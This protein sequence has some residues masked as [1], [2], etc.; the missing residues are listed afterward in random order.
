MSALRSGEMWKETSKRPSPTPA[1][2]TAKAVFPLAPH[3]I[4]TTFLDD[5]VL[6]ERAVGLDLGLELLE[7]CDELWANVKSF[8]MSNHSLKVL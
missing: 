2:F 8:I 6:E 5:T 4:F 7:K 3:V 1:L